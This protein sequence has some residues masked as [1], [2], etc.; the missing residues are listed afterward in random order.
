[1]MGLILKGFVWSHKIWAVYVLDIS[2]KA[3]RVGKK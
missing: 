1:M 2:R 3:D